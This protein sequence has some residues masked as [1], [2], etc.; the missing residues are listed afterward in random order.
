MSEDLLKRFDAPVSVTADHYFKEFS[1]YYED[2][3]KSIH[4]SLVKATRRQTE[5]GFEALLD[6]QSEDTE[7]LKQEQV[8]LKAV[9]NLLKV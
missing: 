5:E 2:V 8:K 6:I 3:I 1:I 4:S 9:I 7:H